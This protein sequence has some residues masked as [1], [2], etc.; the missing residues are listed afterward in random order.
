MIRLFLHPPFD[1]EFL[2]AEAP[3][4]SVFVYQPDLVST[5]LS[6][7]VTAP[8]SLTRPTQYEAVTVCARFMLHVL[9]PTVAYI[10]ESADEDD[11]TEG[12]DSPE[13]QGNMNIRKQ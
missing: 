9:K 10:A 4:P 6:Q 11:T 8:S 2:P 5:S 1:L 3:S 12:Q 13:Y 7:S